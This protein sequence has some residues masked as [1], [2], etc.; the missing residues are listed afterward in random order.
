MLLQPSLLPLTG[1]ITSMPKGSIRSFFD[2]DVQESSP[3]A[4]SQVSLDPS[5]SIHSAPSRT[6]TL[7]SAVKL[8]TLRR[9]DTSNESFINLKTPLLE[10][11]LSS[12][13][14]LN[15]ALRDARNGQTFY[16]VKTLGNASAIV[17]SGYDGDLVKAAEFRWPKIPTGR[18]GNMDTDGVVITMRGARW[19]GT[20]TL[21][22]PGSFLRC[23]SL[24][25][26]DEQ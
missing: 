17:R 13:S 24:F 1:S 16:T 10:L 2:N 12:P 5:S 21:L 14:F 25:L 15:A 19:K 4:R 8:P 26:L 11:E 7:F 20:E 3:H 9:S 23:V 6:T 18:K 22:R